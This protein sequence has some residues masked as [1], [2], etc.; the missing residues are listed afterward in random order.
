[1][2]TAREFKGQSLIALPT[3]YVV[4]DTETTGLD[5]DICNLIEVSAL[6]V[7]GCQV[8]DS[9]SSLVR[10][11]LRYTIGHLTF[12]EEWA[13]EELDEEQNEELRNDSNVKAEYVNPFIADLTGITNEMLA[14]APGPVA[15][16]PELKEFIGDDLLLGHNV[17]FDVNFLYDAFEK[18][19]GEPLRNNFIDNLRIARKVL[20]DLKHH[21]LS[22]VSEKLHISY[23]GAHRSEADCYITHNCYLKLREKIL[24]MGS[25]ENFIRSFTYTPYNPRA[26]RNPEYAEADVEYDDP[27][28]FAFEGKTFV[29]TGQIGDYS[30]STLTKMVETRGGQVKSSVSKTIDYLIVGYED[31]T[32]VIDSAKAKS[33]K[34]I[35]AEQLRDNGGKIKILPDEF[36]LE[37]LE[38]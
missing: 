13:D 24:E 12:S 14:E 35:Y 22:D 27:D 2:S 34:I 1:M 31:R 36:F 10:P 38:H 11:P 17:H 3:D 16:I 26:S 20:R 25:E 28:G 37:A 15:V 8:V 19:L 29:F 4:I 9:Y 33:S 21:R 6:R 18:I 32:V 30:R 7:R 5:Y 23:E